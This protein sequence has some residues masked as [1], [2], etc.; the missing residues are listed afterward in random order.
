VVV[1]YTAEVG[2][3]AWESIDL[4]FNFATG[5]WEGSIPATGS[6]DFFVQAVDRAGNV[7]MFAGNEYFTP[8]ALDVTGPSIAR[9]GEEI[10]FSAVLPPGLVDP[11]LLWE[12]G[13]G[14]VTEG[15][16]TVTHAYTSEGTFTIRVR[17]R[18]ETG[19][20]SV[21]DTNVLVVES[22]VEPLDEIR[23]IIQDLP[24]E[25]FDG[26]ARNRRRTLLKKLEVI[27]EQIEKNAIQGA[28][29][30]LNNDLLGKMDGCGS[31]PDNDDW[32]VNCEVQITLRILI[33]LLVEDLEL[34]L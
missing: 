1:T 25:D 9:I 34:L 7:A 3:S 31:V 5:L 20:L 13:D 32:I 11:N 19:H 14:A 21:A 18:D 29:D 26:P 23:E 28:I 4:S 6:I 17:L 22:A 2:G 30:K 33:D 24:D 16:E 8:V 27:E 12:F 10:S 15:P